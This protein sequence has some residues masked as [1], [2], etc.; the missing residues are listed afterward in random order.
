M[1]AMIVW[2]TEKTQSRTTQK[3]QSMS[4]VPR[5]SWFSPPWKRRF[6]IRTAA[7]SAYVGG[8]YGGW[9]CMLPLTAP[10][11]RR[12]EDVLRRVEHADHGV[13]FAAHDT[14]RGERAVDRVLAVREHDWRAPSR[15]PLTTIIVTCVVLTGCV[16][17][18][19]D[20]GLGAAVGVGIRAVQ[21]DVKGEV[22]RRVGARPHRR[23]QRLLS[24]AR[25]RLKL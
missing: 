16:D 1:L 2:L 25:R 13:A 14:G 23:R 17:G 9:G 18:G 10:G 22:V 11:E 4:L 6:S 15:T 7:I 19:L 20:G 3:A 21:P 12:V 5:W 8:A 24:L